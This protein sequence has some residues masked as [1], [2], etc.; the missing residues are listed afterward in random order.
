MS[1]EKRGLYGKY[2]VTDVVG[3]EAEDEFF[4]LRPDR[5]KHAKTVAEVFPDVIAAHRGHWVVRKVEQW[6]GG[7]GRGEMATPIYSNPLPDAVALP[8]ADAHVRVVLSAYAGAVESENPALAV[9]LRFMLSAV[10]NRALP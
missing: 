2:S 3:R 10:G 9:D 8:V 5:D 6:E 1:D 4:I 7:M